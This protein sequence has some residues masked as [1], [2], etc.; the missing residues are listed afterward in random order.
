MSAPTTNSGKGRGESLRDR[1]SRRTLA[2]TFPRHPEQ[3]TEQNP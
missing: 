1:S 3:Q 2:A